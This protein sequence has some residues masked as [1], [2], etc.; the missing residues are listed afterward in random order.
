MLAVEMEASAVAAAATAYI[1]CH[2]VESLRLLC[3]LPVLVGLLC[4]VM[5]IVVC[6]CWMLMSSAAYSRR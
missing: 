5:L 1:V 3:S 6:H 4:H 2:Q